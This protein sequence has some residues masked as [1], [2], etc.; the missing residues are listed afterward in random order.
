MRVISYG[1][2][3]QS[4][5]LI[6]LAAQGRIEPVDAAIFANVGD[7]SEKP[8]TLRFIR[9][10]VGPWAADRGVTVIEV[11]RPGSTLLQQAMIDGARGSTPLPLKLTRGGLVRGVANRTCTIKWKAAVVARWLRSN[12]ATAKTPAELLIGFST[13]EFERATTGRDRRY[14][15]RRFPL[16]EMGLDRVACSSIIRDAG[17]PVPPKSACWFCPYHRVQQW[18]TMKRDDPETF[19]AVGVIEA[20]LNEGRAALGRDPMWFTKSPLDDV[21]E[22]DPALFDDDGGCDSGFCWT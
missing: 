6:V 7:D 11:A 2:G 12:G 16:L 5:A 14:E 22:A 3:V 20:T 9:E 18:R 8:A 15:R 13:D 17:L 19:V 21:D 10:V 4:T 1:G